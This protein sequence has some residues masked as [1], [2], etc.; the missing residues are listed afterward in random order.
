MVL[1]NPAPITHRPLALR[2]LPDPQPGPGEI[3]VR[4]QACGICRTDL[5]VVEGE[6]P[7]KHPQIIP[8]HQVAGTVDAL[9]PG[10]T[11]FKVGDPI[12]IAWLRYTCGK[13]RY[14]LAG[15]ENLC[16]NARFTG[17]DEN[18][19]YADFALVCE[20][21][22]YA[23]PRSLDPVTATPL[24]C[25]G[26]IGYRALKRAD[27]RHGCRLGLYGFG[28][29]AHICIQ[30]AKH[31]G[32]TVYVMTRNEHHQQLALRLG[33]AWAGP[34]Q[35]RPPDLLDSAILFAPVGD[36][37]PT[38]MEALEKGGTLAIAGIYL[39]DIP[40]LNYE[41]HLS[42]EKNVRS[43]TANTRKD[44]QELL[45]LAGQIPLRPHTTPFPLTEA[46]DALLTLK[47]DAINGSGVLVVS[48]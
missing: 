40:R 17:Y 31:W 4:V 7:P 13:C 33:A 35:A 1:S 29:S 28:S 30:V 11:R 26:I 10:S 47:R 9:G 32:C 41:K 21:F 48:S 25:A 5:H 34:S 3:R 43:V 16:P 44:G 45:A 23:L 37:V 42:S 20:D 2:D 22:A 19:G 39:T 14:C 36:L 15:S 46:N 18:G 38:A 27:V 12:G 8:G 24:L 6:L